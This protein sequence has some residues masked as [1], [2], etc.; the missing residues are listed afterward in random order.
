MPLTYRGVSVGHVRADVV[1][2]GDEGSC[3]V[4]L[5]ATS[6]APNEAER[7]QAARYAQLLGARWAMVVNFGCPT[8]QVARNIV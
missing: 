8:L 2:L 5:K 6:H 3:V 1:A 4:E 7:R